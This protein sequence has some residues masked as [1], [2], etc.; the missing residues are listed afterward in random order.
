MRRT[1]STA[2]LIVNF[3]LLLG[4]LVVAIWWFSHTVHDVGVVTAKWQET[5]T[6]TCSSSDKNCRPSTTTSYYIQL[7]NG[8]VYSFLW[9]TRDWDPVQVNHKIRLTAHGMSLRFYGWRVTVPQIQSDYTVGP[10]E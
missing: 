3:A 4:L 10:P 9:G 8:N 1:R 2:E 7:D 5:T 6:S